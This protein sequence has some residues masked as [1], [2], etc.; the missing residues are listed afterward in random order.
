MR[1]ARRSALAAV[2][3][4]RS[5]RRPRRSEPG[6]CAR[7]AYLRNRTL[8]KRTMGANLPA[9]RERLQG[10]DLLRG[11]VIVIMALDHVRDFWSPTPFRPEDLSQAYP[12]LFLTRWITHYCAPIFVF[13]AGTSAWLYAQST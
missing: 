9:I 13:L 1:R 5:E 10:I 11:L 8:G 7:L 2:A 3:T 4:P 12:T 6:A